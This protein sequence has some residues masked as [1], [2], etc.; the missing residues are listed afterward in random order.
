[1]GANLL[2]VCIRSVSDASASQS[3]EHSNTNE[4]IRIRLCCDNFLADGRNLDIAW[5]LLAVFMC[6]WY[7][8]CLG[9]LIHPRDKA[10]DSRAACERLGR[11]S[12]QRTTEGRCCR[13]KQI[14]ISKRAAW[15]TKH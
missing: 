8:L 15:E 5:L 10:A 11:R 2:V 3:S 6:N 7:D 12:T 14:L 4:S 9:L 1:M 13:Q